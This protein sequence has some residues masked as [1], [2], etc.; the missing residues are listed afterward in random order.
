[1]I[2]LCLCS[3]VISVTPAVA[4]SAHTLLIGS[5]IHAATRLPGPI[6]PGEIVSILGTAL[7]PS[8]GVSY[9]LNSASGA[10]DTTLQGTRVLFSSVPAPILYSSASQIIAIVPHEVGGQSQVIVQVEYQG[11]SA[12]QTVPVASASPGAFITGGTGSGP[13]VA[14]NQNGSVN[15]P[16][17]P[18]A[19][20]SKVTIYFTGGGETIPPGVT[21]SVANVPSNLTQPIL[22]RVGGE[23]ATV[24]YAGAAALFVDG[25]D[26]LTIQL[27]PNTRSGAQLLMITIAGISS[28]ASATL[29]IQ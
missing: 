10:I 27:P 29:S 1:M 7:G 18:A 25:V 23:Q 16:S 2:L 14:L 17:S 20:G 28:P 3:T 12:T 13:A 21:G 4:P 24:L 9:V 11:A 22:V 26:Q 6:A 8:T 19:Q 5:V 15:S